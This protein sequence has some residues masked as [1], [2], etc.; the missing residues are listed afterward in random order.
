LAR[1][2]LAAALR[3]LAAGRAWRGELGAR[4]GTRV[5]PVPRRTPADPSLAG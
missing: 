1:G 5:L 2:R 3:H 4:L